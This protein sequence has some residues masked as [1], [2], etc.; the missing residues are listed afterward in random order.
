M[1]WPWTKDEPPEGVTLEEQERNEIEEARRK[2]RELLERAVD[3]G[4]EADNLLRR[5]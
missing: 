3:L 1:K 5:W 4:I 2:A